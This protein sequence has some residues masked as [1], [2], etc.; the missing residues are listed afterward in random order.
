[1]VARHACLMSL[2]CNDNEAHHD[3]CS[4]THC[5]M[6]SPICQVLLLHIIPCPRSFIPALHL[7]SPPTSRSK[8]TLPSVLLEVALQFPKDLRFMATQIRHL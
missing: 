2:V 8:Q 4:D 3:L 7:F 6:L 5:P 1:M